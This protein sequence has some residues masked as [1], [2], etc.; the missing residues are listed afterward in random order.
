M[1]TAQRIIK[2]TISLLTGDIF[3]K[4]LVFVV[5][6]Y[7][8]RVLG[9]GSFGKINFAMAIVAY[10]TLIADLGLPIVGT[11][12]VARER[13]KIKDYLARILT[14]RLCLAVFGLGLLA[15]IT[16]FLD[17]PIEIKYLIILYG[18]GLIPSALLLDWAF[19]GVEK[20]EYIGLGRI[21]ASV[22]YMGLVLWFVKSYEQLLLV[23]CFQVAGNLLAAGLLISIFVKNFGLPKLK[24][25][26]TLW[27]RL[28]LQALPIGFSLVMTQIFYNIDTV[29]LGFMRSNEEVGYYNAAYKIILFL[30]LLI[31]AY[32]EAIFPLISSYYKTS[33]DS[34]RKLLSITEKLMVTVAIPLAVGGTILASSIMNSL[35]GAKY[36][37]GVIA[38]QI[39]IWAVLIVCINTG[40]S[41]GIL[42]CKKENWYMAGTTIPA[43][44]NVT[45]NLILIP[46]LGITGA[47]IATVLAEASGFI[48]MYVGFKKV[49][50][51]PFKG[52]IVRPLFAAVIMGLVLL[53][54]LKW[55]SSNV[56]LLLFLGVLV[57][58]IT[59]CLARGV[60]R[61]EIRL[62]RGTF[63]GILE[64]TR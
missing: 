34:L 46:R 44:V 42:A 12:E 51:V 23:P 1:N 4:L 5:I 18:L 37:N 62:I 63:Y 35:F 24:F 39:L 16:F 3:A 10:F 32:H 30:I 13:G 47:A 57:Y 60:T 56:F 14:L 49:L 55:W 21:L 58:T 17:K 28:I 7:L 27:R 54:T 40:Y 53:G 61:E 41:R 25:N 8:A 15:L 11:R 38:F 33:L 64:A 6:V 48:V 22:V 50:N 43:I 52:Y 19:Q 59:L 26:F 9:P 31:G 29:I 36:A 45:F 2:N 20:M